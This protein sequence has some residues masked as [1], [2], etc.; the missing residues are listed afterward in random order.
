[1]MAAGMIEYDHD[2]SDM[3]IKMPV[4]S[5][6]VLGQAAWYSTGFG[7]CLPGGLLGV[8][9]YVMSEW[10]HSAHRVHSWVQCEVSQT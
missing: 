1:M 8:P 4:M 10:G 3:I 6:V 5:P 2:A 9:F 7:C